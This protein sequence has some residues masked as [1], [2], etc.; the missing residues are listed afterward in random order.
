MLEY[1]DITP[2]SVSVMGLMNDDDHHVL[3]LVDED[4]MQE[5]YIGFHPCINTSSVKLKT[6][7]LFKKVLK[8]I[9]H[10]YTII[11]C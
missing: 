1:L 10:D 11:H 8:E 2:G 3:L 4:L 7:D 6:E 9:N 5:E